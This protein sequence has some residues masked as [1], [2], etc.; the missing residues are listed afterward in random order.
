MWRI[1]WMLVLTAG[2]STQLSSGEQAIIGG[3]RSTGMAAT[4]L[5]ASFP[6]NRS[7]LYTCTAVVVSPTVLLTAAHCVDTPHH[8]NFIYGVFTGDDASAYPTLAE[9]EPH[10]ERVTSVKAHP[11]YQTQLPFFADLGV[12][13]LAA[14]TA[15]TPLPL[16]RMAIDQTMIGKPA[17]I[18]GYGQTVYQTRNAA[19]FEAM[20]TVGAIDVDTVTIGDDQR[21]GCLGDSG[22]PAIVEGTLVGIDSYGPTACD[23]PAHYRRVDYF[24]PFIDT[25]VP[26]PGAAPDAGVSG[27]AGLDDSGDGGCSTGGG[28]GLVIALALLGLRRRR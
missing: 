11:D 9:L 20:T 21:H 6:A 22:G 19:R 4:V 16:Q 13:K 25:F 12:V 7:T 18:V 24:L 27:D 2:C 26:P 14:P 15:I 17:Q 5:L 28:A 8:P 1:G 23:G 3:T 10:L